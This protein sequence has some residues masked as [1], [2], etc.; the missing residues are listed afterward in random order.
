MKKPLHS[1]LLLGAFLTVA[2]WLQ[3]QTP[4]PMASQNGLVYV[5]NFNDISNWSNNFTSG[6]GASR[7]KGIA[8]GGSGSI[9]AATRITTATTSFSTG[10]TGG[11]AEIGRAHV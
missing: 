10:T 6:V 5:E 11:E 1:L 7:W 3:A 9:P 2:G 8:T 4:V